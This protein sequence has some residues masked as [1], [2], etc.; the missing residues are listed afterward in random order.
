MVLHSRL[1]RRVLI[2][3]RFDIFHIGVRYHFFPYNSFIFTTLAPQTFV[4]IYTELRIYLYMFRRPSQPIFFF[5]KRKSMRHKTIKS[6]KITLPSCIHVNC[7]AGTGI[8]KGSFICRTPQCF[9]NQLCSK[10][11]FSKEVL[12]SFALFDYI[13]TSICIA[14]Y[15]NMFHESNVRTHFLACTSIFVAFDEINNFSSDHDEKYIF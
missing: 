5:E 9:W 15:I 4:S 3:L 10:S 6:G 2:L 7:C 13:F 14:K 11:S 1:P 12:F 8:P